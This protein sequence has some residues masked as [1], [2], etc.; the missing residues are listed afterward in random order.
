V[1][2]FRIQPDGR[3]DLVASE[4]GPGEVE[5]LRDWFRYT[6]PIGH[7]LKIV[8]RPI[9]DCDSVLNVFAAGT[10]PDE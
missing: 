9:S 6:K 10:E 3:E 4:L 8:A 7:G 1:D 2:V 5:E